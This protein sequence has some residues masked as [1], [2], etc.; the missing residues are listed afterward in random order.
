MAERRHQPLVTAVYLER[1]AD[2]RSATVA[3][4]VDFGVVAGSRLGWA[5]WHRWPRLDL[6]AAG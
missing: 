1:P 4:L 3:G 6:S 5:D 2:Q